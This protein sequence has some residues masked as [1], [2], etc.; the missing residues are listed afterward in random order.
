MIAFVGDGCIAHDGWPLESLLLAFHDI[1]GAAPPMVEHVARDQWPHAAEG[2]TLVFVVA[3][4]ACRRLYDC[5]PAPGTV[6]HL[7]SELRA[8]ALGI[9]DCTAPEA[10]RATVRLG[11]SIDLLCAVLGGI[12]AAEL[13]PGDAAGALSESDAARVVAAR[14]MIDERWHEKLTLDGIARACGINRAKLTRGFRT[15]YATSIGD[16]LTDKRLEGARRLL[17]ITDLPVSAIGYRCGYMN[18]ASFTR[19]FTRRYGM[20]P[21]RARAE[22]IAA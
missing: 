3:E 20:P 5:V 7:P 21:T 6:W 22:R 4:A 16:L 11:R 2:A 9:R 19:A 17:S 8:M 10:A 18:N 12:A 14:R 13:I 1:D 15:M